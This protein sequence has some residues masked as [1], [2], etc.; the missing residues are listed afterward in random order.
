MLHAAEV[1]DEH[2]GF[3]RATALLLDLPAGRKGW[4][5][6]RTRAVARGIYRDCGS[7][8]AVI[9]GPLGLFEQRDPHAG[10]RDRRRA[11]APRRPDVV[12]DGRVDVRRARVGASRMG[13]RAAWSASLA[14]GRRR[15][16]RALAEHGAGG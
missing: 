10:H 13:P 4:V 7:Y 16:R 15:A 2:P 12:A 5:G 6:L 11:P 9:T 3:E 14:T 1:Y 8:G